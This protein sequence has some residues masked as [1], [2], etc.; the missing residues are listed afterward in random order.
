MNYVMR[1]GR[2]IEVVTFEA[3]TNSSKK[4]KPFTAQWVK[5]PRRWFV[6]LQRSKSASTYQLALAIQF[7]VFKRHGGEIILSST[8][9]RMPRSTKM[10]AVRELVELGL[11]KIKQRGNQA[12]RVSILSIKEQE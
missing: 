4:R 10:R 6:S 1:H 9:T 2:R 7:E 5:F 8:V 3:A 12:V 11:I